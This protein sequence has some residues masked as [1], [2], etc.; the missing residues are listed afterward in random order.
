VTPTELR[1]PLPGKQATVR[2]AADLAPLL[3]A[4]D[5]LLLDGPLGAGKTFF[6]QALAKALGLLPETRVTSPTF[7]LVHEHATEPRLVHA[8]LYRLSDDERGVRELGLLEQRDDG[9]LLV[10][11]WGLAFERL[12]GGDA[13]VLRLARE[14]GNARIAA[15]SATGSRSGQLLEAL[16]R[17]EVE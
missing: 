17:I 12:L 10:V 15:I 5:L 7:T 2:L 9:A 13:L 11:E 3:G 4:G 16:A 6:V 8:D 1:R 14:L